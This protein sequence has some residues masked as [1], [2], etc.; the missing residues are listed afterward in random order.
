MLLWV[1]HVLL[2]YF[3]HMSWHGE[4]CRNKGRFSRYFLP[5]PMNDWAYVFTELSCYIEVVIHE[6][7]ALDN[8][9]YRKCPM[10]LKYGSTCNPIITQLRED[11]T[12]LIGRE[13]GAA[14]KVMA[15]WILTGQGAVVV[16]RRRRDNW[17]TSGVILNSFVKV[18][19]FEGLLE[20]EK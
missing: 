17:Y 14:T 8:T 15:D 12:S 9:V 18:T 6:V 1:R 13:E 2:I 16:G 5:T 7:W 4:T 19:S 20:R 3:K 11:S 10:A